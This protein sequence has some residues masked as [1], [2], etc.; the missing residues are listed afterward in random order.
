MKVKKLYTAGDGF[1]YNHH[2]PMWSELLAEILDCEW[3][4]LSTFGAGNEA[5]A[6]LVLDRLSTDQELEESLWLVQWTGPKRFDLKIDPMTSKLFNTI[7]QDDVYY[8]NFITSSKNHRYW[9]SSASV[10]PFVSEYKNSIPTSQHIDRSRMIQLGLAYAL[11]Q[12]NVS[13]KYLFT[14]NS[15]WA[16][17][18]FIP[19]DHIVW[20]SQEEFRSVSKYKDLDVGEVQ[21]ISSVHL[22]FLEQFILPQ[23]THDVDKFN[24]I[25]ERIIAD[26][27]AR[28]FKE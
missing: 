5:I 18:N 2:W 1:C 9:C 6:N 17:D 24:S 25:K 12:S 26:D 13:W 4:N 15:S 21:P 8:D 16:R 23:L 3:V 27:T 7:Q 11:T 20:R 22:D 28:K 19:N 14:Y 10:L